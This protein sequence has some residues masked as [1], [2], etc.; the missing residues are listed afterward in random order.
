MQD[1]IRYGEAMPDPRG[2]NATMY[3]TTMYKNGKMYNLEVCMMKFRIQ[4][5]ILSMQEKQWETCQQ[6]LSKEEGVMKNHDR[7][8]AIILSN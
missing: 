3:Y 5:I 1:A 8:R 2:S 4:C 6:Y 7:K